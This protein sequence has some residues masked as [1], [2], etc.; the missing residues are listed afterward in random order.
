MDA[1]NVARKSENEEIGCAAARD[2]VRTV[3]VN[4]Q[5]ESRIP[6]HAP[7]ESFPVMTSGTVATENFLPH[8][9]NWDV[10]L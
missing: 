2:L 10:L 9:K 7:G 3:R 6:R 8:F 4:E 5:A 1:A